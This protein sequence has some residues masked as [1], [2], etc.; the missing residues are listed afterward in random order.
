MDEPSV[1][2]NIDL[3]FVIHNHQPVGNFD[4]VI[5]K[6]YQ[7]GY[8]PFIGFLEKYPFFRVGLHYSG[9]LWEYIVDNHPDFIERIKALIERN[10]IEL[11]G[12]SYYESVVSVLPD[13]EAVMQLSSYR[14]TIDDFCGR[15]VEGIWLAERVWEPCLPTV[16]SRAGYKYTFLDQAHFEAGG[17][18][19]DEIWGFY[20]SEDRGREVKIFPI[21][22]TLRYN[23]PFQLP[24]KTIEYIEKRSGSG[25]EL[26]TYGD[27]GEKFGGWP[28]TKKWVYE[29]KWLENFL[30]A[31]KE[32]PW[33]KLTLPSEAVL[34]HRPLGNVYLPCAS[35][36]EMGEWTLPVDI[37][38]E[39]FRLKKDLEPTGLKDRVLPLI[40]GGFWRQ[41]FAKYPESGRIYRRLLRVCSQVETM[42][43]QD[44][45]EAKKARTALMR[46]AANDAYWHGVFGGIYLPHLRH[47]VTKE[48]ITAETI[49]SRTSGLPVIKK[50]FDDK[51]VS[52]ANDK[53]NVIVE[54]EEGGA[55]SGI[56]LRLSGVNLADSIARRHEAYHV[57]LQE[58]S[59]TNEDD[60]SSIHDRIESKE[61]DL[62]EKLII[63]DHQRLCFLDRFIRNDVT[64]DD[65]QRNNDVDLCKVYNTVYSILKQEKRKVTL[66]GTAALQDS[67]IEF[68]KT[69]RLN[70]NEAVIKVE[71]DFI[72][73]ISRIESVL[74]AP[75]I[76][77]NLLAP[78]ADDRYFLINGKSFKG[79]NLR[80]MGE[81]QKCK[82]LSLVD[83]YLG[84][85]VDLRANP[86]PKWMWYPIETVSLSEG[87][88]ESVYQG[89]GIH[90]VWELNRL[91]R[92][93]PVIT[94]SIE[95]WKPILNF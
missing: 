20:R 47:A 49:F 86:Q 12:G 95:S 85:R 63:D 74:F 46:G 26:I 48:L 55:I 43:M 93:K 41:Y 2:K 22:K 35:Y 73:D 30:D 80:S 56:D 88:A 23:I 15:S 52:L 50:E 6:N 11:V 94:M 29:D 76:H 21:D 53:L 25:V 45:P 59:E 18:P 90:P 66:S 75:E 60:H 38:V 64:L 70:Q 1:H 57:R 32:N 67:A 62:L 3:V 61:D 54:P 72:S 13:Y 31:F 24:Q 33:I 77:I 78:D 7:D 9:Y 8:E 89:S 5:E 14:E 4:F 92:I 10:Q 58:D 81:P 44:L 34:M 42:E 19:S 28:G 82:I 65:L 91:S 16:L 37:Q 84:I 87:G 68:S 27:D 39:L 79:N 69:Y 36:E 71:Y 83:D 17:V 51:I 40:R